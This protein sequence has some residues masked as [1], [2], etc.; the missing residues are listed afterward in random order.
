MFEVTDD[1]LLNQLID[2][3]SLEDHSSDHFSGSFA[4]TTAKAWKVK[5]WPSREELEAMPRRFELYDHSRQF[6]HAVYCGREP[7][8]LYL[9][10]GNW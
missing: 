8:R 6:Y 5:W 7:D 4:A 10:Y 9:E 3:W 2:E 1:E